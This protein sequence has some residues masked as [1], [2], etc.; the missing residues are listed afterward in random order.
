MNEFYKLI[1]D[2][3]LDKEKLVKKR[4]HFLNIDKIKADYISKIYS[5]K[6]VDLS[7]LSLKKIGEL[8]SMPIEPVESLTKELIEK[9]LIS[10]KNI[11]NEFVFDFNL[12]INKLIGSY[13]AP[14]ENKAIE[15]KM[16]W[17]INSLEFELTDT[18]KK[19]LRLIIEE[20]G[21]N[22]LMLV[23]NK[24]ITLDNQSW[25]QLISMYEAIGIKEKKK[26]DEVKDILTKNW[27]EE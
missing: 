23:I 7:C 1:K 11:E 22:D 19:D 25:H 3:V 6:N 13:I 2:D 24:L 8:L 26:S 9:N 27:L 21:W 10:I 14:N 18:N 17:V 15:E 16:N 5:F 20:K 12:L 4:Y